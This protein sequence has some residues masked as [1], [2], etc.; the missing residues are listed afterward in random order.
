LYSSEAVALVKKDLLS[1]AV[2]SS[3]SFA[4]PRWDWPA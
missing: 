3:E 1:T 2:T 4:A